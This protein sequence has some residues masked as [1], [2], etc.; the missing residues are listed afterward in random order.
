MSL[1][2]FTFDSYKDYV[3]GWISNQPKSGHG[4]LGRLAKHLL[5]H[6]VVMSQVFRGSR[7]LTLEQAASVTAFVGLSD[8]ERDY[9]LL[10]VNRDRA[11]TRELQAILDRQ[12]KVLRKDSKEL[13]TRIQHKA[14]ADDQK[15]IFYSHWYYS[16]IRL[17]LSIPGIQS[18]SAIAEHLS[19]SPELVVRVLRFLLDCGLVT[20]HEG[21]LQMGPSVTHVGH[22]SPFVARHHTNW[23]LQGLRALD[24]NSSTSE[25]SLFYSGPMALSEFAALNIRNDVVSL[26]ERAT[27]VA[28]HSDS[29]VLRCLNLDWFSPK[30]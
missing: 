26:I 1:N 29:E 18:A 22:D 3:N 12:I 21:Q 30:E 17:S 7:D 9:F 20:K 13:K 2:L 27:K 15:A 5:V 19:L 16:A 14:L 4:L 8:I 24:R 23:R 10:L 11:G 6:P 25:N 28:A